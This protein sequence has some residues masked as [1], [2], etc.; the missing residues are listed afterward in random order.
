MCSYRSAKYVEATKHL[1]WKNVLDLYPH[2]TASYFDTISRC[3]TA[4][5][6]E[7]RKRV[8]GYGSSSL[9]AASST[10]QYYDSILVTRLDIVDGIKSTY[11]KKYLHWF[12]SRET[13]G[14]VG[15]KPWKPPKQYKKVKYSKY[16]LEDR[17]IVGKAH[18]M[19]K[20]SKLYKFYTGQSADTRDLSPE[21]TL[22]HFF[23]ENNI[24]MGLFEDYFSIANFTVNFDKYKRSFDAS[25]RA[26]G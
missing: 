1:G 20:L 19:V 14:L 17:L 21:L 8:S 24:R 22:K 13:M 2:R 15:L 7:S 4:V 18:D 26:A 9:M 6:A 3:A 12:T 10:L 5:A 25:L 11:S 23:K 16:L